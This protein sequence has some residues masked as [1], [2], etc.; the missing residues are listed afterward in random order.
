[1][2]V[3]YE[4]KSNNL[5]V[6]YIAQ[7]GSIKL[8]SFPWRNPLQWERCEKNDPEADPIKIAWDRGSVKQV[9]VKV[10]SRHAVYEFLDELP[11]QERLEIFS[12][13]DPDVFFVDIETE[14][15]GEFP[16]PK[17]A[18]NRI[19]SLSIIHKDKALALGLRDLSD[20][21]CRDIEAN[22]AKH[23]ADKNKAHRFKYIKFNTEYDMIYYF[24]ARL[25][26]KMAVL[27]GWNFVDF[28]WVYLVNRARKLGIDP[29]LSSFTNRLKEVY[30]TDIELPM[31]RV[32]VDYKELYDKWDTSVKVK[33][34]SSLDFVSSKILNIKKVAYERGLDDLYRDDFKKFIFYNVVDS[35]LV[36]LIHE[37]Q[38]YANIMFAIADIS[39]IKILDAFSTIQTT[40]GLLR[41]QYREE[42]NIVFTRD[43]NDVEGSIEGGFVKPPHKG[44]R[45]WTVVY[46]FASLYPTTMR[47]FNIGPEMFMGVVNPDDTTKCIYKNIVRDIDPEQDVVLVNGAVFRKGKSVMSD[48]LARV[49]SERKRYKKMMLAK[50]DE[51]KA[52]EKKISDLEMLVLK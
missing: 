7:D 3:D 44:M 30:M 5:I 2:L 13:A 14:I 25:V 11:E 8:K 21:D 23:F 33:E 46:D 20:K 52:L 12:Y 24:F 51:R 16:E 26:P 31:H 6:S 47:Q 42:M 36:Q 41:K 32:I 48:M 1:M 43:K 34:S 40:E 49:Y 18:P 22:L 9:S 39:N 10:P 37:K 27:T 45:D 35:V 19:L 29:A 17:D 4:Y 15:A 28:D 38:Q 50:R